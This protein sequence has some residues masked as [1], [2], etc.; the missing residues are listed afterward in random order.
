MLV[1]LC[2]LTV[3]RAGTVSCPT[4]DVVGLDMLRYHR[5]LAQQTTVNT[6]R[7]DTFEGIMERFMCV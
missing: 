2:G 3:L 6:Y 4:K 5:A 1:V 7:H